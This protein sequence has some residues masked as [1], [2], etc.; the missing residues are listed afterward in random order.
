MQLIRTLVDAVI[1]CLVSR[2]QGGVAV[3]VAIGLMLGLTMEAVAAARLKKTVHQYAL[4]SAND[5]PQRDPQDWR[6]LGSNDGGKTWITVDT[7][8]REVFTERHQ[9]RVFKLSKPATFD[10]FRLQI[11]LVRDPKVANSVQLAEIELLGE[12]EA[13]LDP[14]P[15]FTD[16][17]TSL[18]DNPP[19]ETAIK[20]FDGRVETKWLDNKPR[21][22]STCASWVQWQYAA[23]AEIVVTNISQLTA[24]RA[25]ANDGYRVEL[26]SVVVGRTGNGSELSMADSTGCV[27]L[28]DLQGE[29]DLL[30]GQPVL[31]SG[32]SVWSDGRIAL[33]EGR[34]QLRG[35]RSATTPE[36]I[37]V[38]QPLSRR[39]DLKWVEIEGEVK[40]RLMSNGEASFD[41]YED[42]ASMRVHWRGV[43]E[44]AQLPP[45]GARVIVR[46]VVRGGFNDRGIWV[47]S[48]L[49]TAGADAVTL[50][51]AR[52]RNGTTSTRSAPDV[53]PATLTK[54]EQIRRLTQEQLQSRPHVR[55]RGVVTELMGAFMQDETAGVQVAFQGNEGRKVTEPGTYVEVEGWGG[56]SDAGNPI[57][58]ADRVTVLGKGKW[59]EPQR[60]SLSQLMSGRIDAQWIEV[61]GVV[62]STDG[63]HL[64]MICYG[65]EVTA[66]VSA[67]AAGRV[68]ELVDAAVRVRGVGVTALDDRARIQGVHL[69]IPSLEHVDVT[70]PP[71]DPE[72]L[73]MRPIGSLLGLSGPRESYHRVKVEGVVTLQEGHKIFL[74][75]DSGGA[76][77]MLKED[78]VLDPRFGRSRW[79]FM[80]TPST[81]APLRADLRFSPGDRVQLVGFP[82]TRSYSPVLTEAVA[83]KISSGES[84]PIYTATVTGLNDGRADSMMAV[85]E[86][87][88]LGQNAI[89]AHV[90]MALEWHDRTIQVLVPARESDAAMAIVPGSRLQ[91]TGVCQ[92]DSTP[93]AQLGLRV[94]SVRLLTR[95]M[96]DVVV[97]SRPPWWTVKRALTVMGGMALV[98]LAALVWI[99]QLRKQVEERSQQLA[100]EIQL[101]EQTERRSA[102]EQERARIAKDLHDDLGANLAQIVFLSQRVD[103]GRNDLKEVDRYFRMIPATARKTIQS[104]DEIVWA[105]NPRHDLVESLANYLSQFAA[106]HLTL[107]GVRCI[108]DVPMVLPEIH[109][110]AEVRHNLVLATREAINNVSTHAAATEA[111]VSL[112]LDETAL[113]IAVADNGRGF[114]PTQTSGDG[115]G[116]SNMRRRLEDVGGKLELES[117]PDKGTVVRFIVARKQLHG[118]VIGGNGHAA[119]T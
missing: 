97:L 14:L 18:D 16:H 38:E 17:I 67:G 27:E 105:I 15:I 56:L 24:L 1:S 114:D 68:K 35:E 36:A 9:R 73:P 107:A 43:S 89:G 20:L 95:S 101:R 91:V 112:A 96:A 3:V 55:F 76:M 8:K 72:K 94:A 45:N 106:E 29:E 57:V 32:T 119:A 81:N 46:G 28:S 47:A 25:R 90:A 22:R 92:V 12:T 50:M 49:W 60:M 88:L 108:L 41:V 70:E 63:A 79:L 44:L 117:A 87:V 54:I 74:Q 6:L 37:V 118:R 78:V 21:D 100:A 4:T 83:T 52:N 23:P 85:V 13:D 59:P 51:D 65:R 110:S 7:R 99:K 34:I 66:S 77:A 82:E 116:L 62:R 104:L 84:V 40:Y 53:L 31:I 39:E 102:L 109:I 86:G 71:A 2:Q 93:Y 58:S 10:T 48:G 33:R 11:D 61:E 113:T 75:D 115:N 69:L 5:F 19:S 42:G 26:M 80:R 64:L 30:P 111:R 103:D 98:I